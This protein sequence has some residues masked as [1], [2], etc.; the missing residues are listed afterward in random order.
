ML[1]VC[2]GYPLSSTER[3]VTFYA[4]RHVN[5]FIHT[6]WERL[7]FKNDIALI[8]LPEINALVLPKSY[9]ESFAINRICLSPQK[10]FKYEGGERVIVAGFGIKNGSKTHLEAFPMKLTWAAHTVDTMQACEAHP[11]GYFHENQTFCTF[12]LDDEYPHLCKVSKL[13]L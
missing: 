9:S 1:S 5:V 10:P 4:K 3:S 6:N 7:T 8:F 13:Q 12:S 11:N 2:T